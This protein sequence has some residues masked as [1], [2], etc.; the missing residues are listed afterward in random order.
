MF[1]TNLFVV[2]AIYSSI[3]RTLGKF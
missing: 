3:W 1:H 2:V